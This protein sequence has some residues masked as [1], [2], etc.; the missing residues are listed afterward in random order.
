MHYF[1]FLGLIYSDNIYTTISKILNK[2]WK[3][4]STIF[5]FGG[6]SAKA[7]FREQNKKN[8]K[9]E[10]NFYSFFNSK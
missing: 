9:K 10:Y 3:I 7:K 2:I 4:V 5:Y 1:A 6:A 8:K